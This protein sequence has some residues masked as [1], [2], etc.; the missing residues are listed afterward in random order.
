[1]SSSSLDD[2]SGIENH[3]GLDPDAVGSE[4]VVFAGVVIGVTP[5]NGDN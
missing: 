5:A 4:A 3:P 2:S 1:L